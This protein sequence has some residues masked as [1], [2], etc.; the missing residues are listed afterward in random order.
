MTK[1]TI[2]IEKSFDDSKR[3]SKNLESGDLEQFFMEEGE[4]MDKLSD[5]LESKGSL[6]DSFELTYKIK[7]EKI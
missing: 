4:Y 3:F 7:V 2:I 6:T 5:M 1:A